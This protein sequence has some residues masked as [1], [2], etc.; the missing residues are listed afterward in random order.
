M[1][2]II[3]QA[4]RLPGPESPE[5]S[6]NHR[7]IEKHFETQSPIRNSYDLAEATYY[8]Q[9]ELRERLPKEAVHLREQVRG[10]YRV[11]ENDVWLIFGE[12]AVG[13]ND[14]PLVLGKR[15]IATHM[16]QNHGWKPL[17]YFASHDVIGSEAGLYRAELPFPHQEQGVQV[18]NLV[19]SRKLGQVPAARIPNHEVDLHTLADQLMTVYGKHSPGLDRLL[20]Q[21]YM[22]FDH[23][24]QSLA[25]A[26]NNLLRRLEF[27]L[28]LHS[29]R[30]AEDLDFDTNLAQQGGLDLIMEQWP[31]LTALAQKHSNS[32]TRVPNAQ[33]APFHAYPKEVPFR[34]RV[35]IEDETQRK[36][37]ATHPFDQ[38][39]IVGRFNHN[40]IMEGK[41]GIT[42]R[43]IPR[44]ILFA[45]IFDAHVTGGGAKYNEVAAP[46][47]EEV[48]QAPYF[49]LV[50]M[51]LVGPDCLEKGVFQYRS[52][53]LRKGKGRGFEK[54]SRLVNQGKAGLF[55]LAL[56]LESGERESVRD[57]LHLPT[58]PMST[59]VSLSAN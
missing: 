53:A 39:E 50:W 31:R 28:G 22:E 47:F 59:R 6:G 49:P 15:L 19:S 41:V 29:R 32:T 33:E 38:S 2:R 4:R 21:M 52:A 51:D 12:Q 3:E 17:E 57:I 10:Q 24:S 14:P 9:Q 44:I 13:L 54:A 48:L 1:T 45:A 34:P 25:A 23:Q 36:Y 42:F 37:V 56:S 18:I 55:D 30:K 58:L 43:A 46:V 40:D 5:D 26:Q 11:G 7:W 8:R 35:W 27:S 16:A 20:G